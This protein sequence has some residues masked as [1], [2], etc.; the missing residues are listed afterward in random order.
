[1]LRTRFINMSFRAQA[2]KLLTVI[3]FILLALL[4]SPVAEGREI[5]TNEDRLVLI[6]PHWEGIRYEFGRAFQAWYVRERGRQVVLD[7]RDMGG[8]SD[9]LRFILSEFKR[10]PDSI[11]VDLFFGGGMDPFVDLKKNGCL[12]PIDLGVGFMAGIPPDISGVPNYDPDFA[13]FG[14]ALSSFG[15]LENTR[16]VQKL[17]LPQVQ[18]W[19]DLAQPGLKGWVGSGDPRNS[20]SV[21]LIYECIL[22]AY[23]WSE[24]WNTLRGIASNIRQFDQSSSTAAKACTLGNVAYAVV[25]DFYGFMQVAEAGAGNMRMIIPEGESVLT[26][27]PIAVIKG[28]PNLEVAKDFVRFVLSDEGQ[29]LWIAPRGH[30]RGARKF[31]IERMPVRPSLYDEFQSENSM[32]QNPFTGNPPLKYRSDVGSLRWGALNGLMGALLIDRPQR[33][34]AVVPLPLT[35]DELNLIARDQWKDPIARNRLLLSWQKLN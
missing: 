14:A 16:V 1:M 15:I 19:R 31:S 24:G 13:W 26:P 6:S 30:P 11:G 34:R 35:E 22:Q 18:S 17:G 27:D 5:P 28:A 20:G 3:L 12:Q 10:T 33:E 25:V 2:R 8:A 7:W 32:L 9:G 21:H 23:G 29:S 4:Q